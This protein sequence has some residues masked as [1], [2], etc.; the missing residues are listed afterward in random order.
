[1]RMQ[2]KVQEAMEETVV[3]IISI[4]RV[5]E[6]RAENLGL[7]PG[8]VTSSLRDFGKSL[9]SSKSHFLSLPTKIIFIVCNVWEFA[10]H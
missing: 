8:S 2:A 4:A 1:M 10:K 6:F 9:N 3:Q 7:N 5:L